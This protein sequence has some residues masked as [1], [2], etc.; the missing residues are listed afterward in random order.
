MTR[1]GI[2]ERRIAADDETTTTLSVQRRRA[3]RWRWPASMPAELDL[4]IVGT[5]TPD[6]PMPA[7]AVLVAIELGATRAAGVRP[8]GRLLGLRLRAGDGATASSAAGCTA[9]CSSSASRSSAG[10]STGPI[11]APACCS[12]TARRRS[13]CSRRPISRAGLVGF[14]LFSDGTGCEG[15]IMPAGGSAR[16][17]SHDT[18][19]ARQ[20]CHPDARQRR[21]QVRDAA[22]RRVG[23]GRAAQRGPHGRRRRPVRLP[24]GEHADHRPACRSS[25][26]S[27]RRR[28]T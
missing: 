6:Y 10:S 9:T 11:A 28:R 27:R 25:S 22:D 19:D 14:D 8:P 17:T 2:R 4:V 7:T 1:T 20:H 13:C 24:P 12:A 23:P 16:P 15:I 18:V 21:L 3:T 5:C 26:A